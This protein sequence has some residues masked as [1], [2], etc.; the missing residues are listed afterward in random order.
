MSKARNYV[1]ESFIIKMQ[2]VLQY[3]F[4]LV[5]MQIACMIG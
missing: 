1:M 4:C 3:N 5:A 2:I